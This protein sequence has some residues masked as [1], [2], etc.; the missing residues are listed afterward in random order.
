MSPMSDQPVTLGVLTTALAQF[1]RE[2]VFPDVQRIVNDAVS[3]SERRLRG[4]I[5]GILQ[6][7]DKLEIEY[8]LLKVGLQRVE[9]RGVALEAR[10][11][12]IEERLD[13]VERQ[14]D[15]LVA[16]LEKDP[17]R[18]E[19]ADLRARVDNLQAQ[20]RSLESRLDR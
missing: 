2:I 1:H 14:V 9:T 13:R 6:K 10:L 18:S 15:S 12:G 11:S 5:D 19:L 20:V 4:Q 8:E 17:L 3:A 16:A 7:L